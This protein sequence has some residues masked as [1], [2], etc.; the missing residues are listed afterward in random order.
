VESSKTRKNP[1]FRPTE[2]FAAV[3]AN[4]VNFETTA[5]DLKI[6]FG[7]LNQSFEPLTVDQHTSVTMSWMEAKLLKHFLDIQLA[8]FEMTSGKIAIPEAILPPEPPRPTE[9]DSKT[10]PKSQ[11]IYDTI[12]KLR[13]DF[14]E[15]S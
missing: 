2:D 4:N 14:I 12:M 15:N 3:Y 5:F 9:E 1:N 10:E 7:E 11:M 8:V 13:K 6:L